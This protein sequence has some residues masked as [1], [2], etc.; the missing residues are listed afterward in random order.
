MHTLVMIACSATKIT[1]PRP[2]PAIEVYD[3][4]MWQTLR[5][6]KGEDA[7]VC[8]LSGKHGFM[9]AGA[10]IRSYEARLSQERAD[11]LIGKGIYANF[12]DW[13]KRRRGMPGGTPWVEAGATGRLSAFRSTPYEYVIIAGADPYLRVFEA[14]GLAFQRDGLI[15]K[16]A[17]SRFTHGGIGEQRGQLGEWLREAA[18]L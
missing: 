17:I 8:V 4:P 9:N 14:F 13:G 15:A 6:H 3:G 7:C 1:Y 16:H 11:Y 5:T 10:Y 2:R 12:D 18:K